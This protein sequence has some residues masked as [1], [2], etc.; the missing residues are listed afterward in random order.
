[1]TRE[2]SRDRFISYISRRAGLS[3]VARRRDGF[4]MIPGLAKLAAVASIRPD[5]IWRGSISIF[6]P[7]RCAQPVSRTTMTSVLAVV[8]TCWGAAC[9]AEVQLPGAVLMARGFTSRLCLRATTVFA[10]LEKANGLFLIRFGFN[11][12]MAG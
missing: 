5:N 10:A 11:F 6:G 8:A 9:P 3:L 4:F 2:A 1:M 12:A 7:R